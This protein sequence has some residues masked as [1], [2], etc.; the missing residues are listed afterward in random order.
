LI[1]LAEEER[2]GT[3]DQGTRPSLDKGRKGGVEVAFAA[4]TQDVEL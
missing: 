2:V 1:A 3:D 4:G